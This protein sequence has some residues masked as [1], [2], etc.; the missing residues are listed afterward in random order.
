MVS[1]ASRAPD[2]LVVRTLEFLGGL[3]QEGGWRPESA[4]PEIAFVG[5]SNVGKSSL[6]NA[7]VR[8]R[9]FARV[10]R[11]PGRTREINFFRVNGDFV[12]VDLPGYGYARVARTR[13]SEWQPLIQRYLRHTAQLRGIVLLLDSRRQPTAEDRAMLEFLADLEIPTLVAITKIDKFGPRAAEVRAQAIRDAL[14][15]DPAQVVAVSAHTGRGRDE[16]AAAIVDLLSHPA[17]RAP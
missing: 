15:L 7:L 4:L 14:E 11:T 17:W 1:P 9:A 2:P 10:S 6:L 13:R 5:R 3:A 16:L 8:R 12:L